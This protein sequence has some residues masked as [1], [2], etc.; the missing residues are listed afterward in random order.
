M[1]KTFY[2]QGFEHILDI[3]A[4]DH[5]LFIISI[6][7]LANFKSWRKLLILVTAFTIGHSLTL[8]LSALDILTI[9]AIII[10]TV[11]P[12]TIILSAVDNIYQSGKEDQFSPKYLLVLVFGFIHG[13]GFSNFFKALLG[14]EENIIGPL[15][16]FNVGVEV[17]QLCIV[18][19]TLLVLYILNRLGVKQKHP[20]IIGSSFIIL[21]SFYLL[22]KVLTQG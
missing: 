20:T 8:V 17:A 18:G 13:M 5:V 19:L 12:I 3:N 16:A 1:F 15:F 22:I 4:Y 7:L 14:K 2:T 9:P 10:E 21:I 6:C 11:I